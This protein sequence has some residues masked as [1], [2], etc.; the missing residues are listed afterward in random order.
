MSKYIKCFTF[1]YKMHTTCTGALYVKVFMA[2]HSR[3][4]YSFASLICEVKIPIFIPDW[5]GVPP[6]N[7]GQAQQMADYTV[8]N[9]D[10]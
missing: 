9:A 4:L 6:A 8:S 2:F 3:D 7:D 1:S 10:S 5:P